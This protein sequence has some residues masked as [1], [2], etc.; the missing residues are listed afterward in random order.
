MGNIPPSELK[1][2]DVVFQNGN[3]IAMSVNFCFIIRMIYID[4]FIR[5]YLHTYR[6]YIRIFN[7]GVGARY[8]I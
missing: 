6:N 5:K 2:T 7:Y 8:D 1:Q 4:A 3:I